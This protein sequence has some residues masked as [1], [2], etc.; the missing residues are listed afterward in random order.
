[1]TEVSFDGAKLSTWTPLRQ[2]KINL[3]DAA[4]ARPNNVRDVSPAIYN[5]GRVAGHTVPRLGAR[6]KKSG[7]TT[8]LT[9]GTITILRAYVQVNYGN[10][11]TLTFDDQI[12]I[13]PRGF[14][15]GGDSG[16]LIVD[17]NNAAVGL[18]FAGS[19][20]FTLANPI[21]KVMQELGIIS[22]L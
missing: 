21:V 16:S 9:Y 8:G 1:L 3:V 12:V 7:R 17:Q 2:N 20:V 13:Q 19:P 15:A 11:G 22:I 6:V 5:I 18:L 4:L 10:L 14:S